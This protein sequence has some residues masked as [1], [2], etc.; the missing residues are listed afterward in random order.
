MFTIN[1]R[2]YENRRTLKKMLCTQFH[3]DQEMNLDFPHTLYKD[4]QIVR[5]W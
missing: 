1:L 2:K 4:K 5:I 3:F